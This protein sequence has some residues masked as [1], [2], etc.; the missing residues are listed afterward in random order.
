MTSS[1]SRADQIV[2]GTL[3]RMSELPYLAGSRW[4][5]LCWSLQEKLA[6]FAASDGGD[7]RERRALEILELVL[8]RVR[9]STEAWLTGGLAGTGRDVERG[10]AHDLLQGGTLQALLA[11]FCRPSVIR[12]DLELTCPR[13]LREGGQAPAHITFLAAQGEGAEDSPTELEARI[14]VRVRARGIRLSAYPAVQEVHLDA[15]GLPLSLEVELVGLRSGPGLLIVEISQGRTLLKI[16][17]AEVDVG[18]LQGPGEDRGRFPFEA[19]GFQA[20][21]PDLV[22]RSELQGQELRL[23]LL[24]DNSEGLATEGNLTLRSDPVSIWKQWRSDL[25]DLARSSTAREDLERFG[26]YLYRELWPEE[27]RSTLEWLID[28]SIRSVQIDSVDEWLIP[29]EL[30]RP[31]RRGGSAKPHCEQDEEFLGTRFDLARWYR[32]NRTTRPR[33]EI[34]LRHVTSVI[35][36]FDD[37]PGTWAEATAIARE[38]ERRGLLL[39]QVQPPDR[40]NTLRALEAAGEPPVD[41]WHFAGHGDHNFVSSDNSALWLEGKTFIEP[42]DLAKAERKLW[43]ERPFVF[44]NACHVGHGGPSLTTTGGW[45]R[46]LVGDCGVGAVLAPLFAVSDQ[47]ATAFAQAFYEHLPYAGKDS[48]P[49]LLAPLVCSLRKIV[50]QSLSDDPGWLAYSLFAHPNA[51]LSLGRL[52]LTD[53]EPKDNEAATTSLPK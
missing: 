8:S 37:L 2:L 21:Q 28:G 49:V 36:R 45:P 44:L 14:P 1:L 23:S 41:L 30:L 16:L 17:R 38:T 20:P 26:S 50:R 32:S 31:Y 46:R 22:I 6:S 39:T 24:F 40:R 4:P 52:K 19:G 47:V 15:Q 11:R 27:L 7:L 12:C 10:P 3:R 13:T 51:K 42:Q 53:G 18:M 35:P 25:D 5:L 48:A 43:A 34:A 9:F 29:W 33:S